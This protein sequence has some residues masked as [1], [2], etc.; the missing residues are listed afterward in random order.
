MT[1][2]PESLAVQSA[3]ARAAGA[4]AGCFMPLIKDLAAMFRWFETGRYV[5][6]PRRQEKLFGP[7]PT[8]KE[9]LARYTDELRSAQHR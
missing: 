9:A 6:G 3:V 7:A 8:A 2:E 1:T 4:V 5:V